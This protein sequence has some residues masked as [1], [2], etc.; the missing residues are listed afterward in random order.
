[1]SDNGR[2]E[3]SPYANPA[4]FEQ[5][6]AAFR[7]EDVADLLERFEREDLACHHMALAA[8]LHHFL[9]L[10]PVDRQVMLI[11]YLD[12]LGREPITGALQLVDGERASRALRDG[13]LRR[14]G[15]VRRTGRRASRRATR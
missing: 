2:D 15:G 12:A 8:C 11:K 13:R 9:S 3:S 5:A 14:G 4:A 6:R 1:M 7:G 10:G